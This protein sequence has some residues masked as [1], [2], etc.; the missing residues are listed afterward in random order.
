MEERFKLDL[1]QQLQYSLSK[2]DLMLVEGAITFL[3]Q[4][5]SIGLKNLN[6]LF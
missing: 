3:F 2:E 4:Q 5:Y 1:L 6:L